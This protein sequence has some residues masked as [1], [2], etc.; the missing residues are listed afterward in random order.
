[1]WPQVNLL[2]AIPLIFEDSWQIWFC[3]MSCLKK[4]VTKGG[5]AVVLAPKEKVFFPLKQAF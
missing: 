2:S 3:E 1:M 5:G 4:V